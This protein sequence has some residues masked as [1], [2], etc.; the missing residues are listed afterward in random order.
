MATGKEKKRELALGESV[1]PVLFSFQFCS[2]RPKLEHA[3]L[4]FRELQDNLL[5]FIC[6]QLLTTR[7]I[8]MISKLN[9]ENGETF[10]RAYFS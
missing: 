4:F 6:L 7:G 3:R 9:H 2:W 10:G 1:C 8:V 5:A